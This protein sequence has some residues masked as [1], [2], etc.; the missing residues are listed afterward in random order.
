[1]EQNSFDKQQLIYHIYIKNANEGH[2]LYYFLKLKYFHALLF[3][4]L[5]ELTFHICTLF[6]VF[7]FI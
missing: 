5:R 4:K 1:M 2:R 6:F 3:V 7:L